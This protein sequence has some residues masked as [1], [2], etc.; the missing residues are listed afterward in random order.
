MTYSDNSHSR[1]CAGLGARIH[2]MARRY[3]SAVLP[4]HY[5]GQ[6]DEG[7]ATDEE[8]VRGMDDLEACLQQGRSI[9]AGGP[10]DVCRATWRGRDVVIK[11][12][13]HVGWM[14]SLRHSFKGS[15]ACRAWAN[16]RRLLRLGISTP[17]PLAFLDEHRGPFLWQSCLITEYVDAP[18]LSC[19]LRD[20]CVSEGRKR[21]LVHQTLRLIDRLG[22]YGIS[23]G[24]MKHTNILCPGSRIV[25]ADLDGMKV[26]R[27][28]WLS[29]SHRRRDIARFLRRMPAYTGEAPAAPQEPEPAFMR[30]EH[31]TGVLWVHRDYRNEYLEK[32]LS[33][34]QEALAEQ[35]RLEPVHS[36]GGS[37]VNRFLAAFQG[38]ERCVYC[39]E[40]VERSV[41]DRLKHLVRPSRAVRDM[42]ASSMLRRYG[43]QTAQ[44]VL[45]GDVRTGLLK[46]T[47][48]LVTLEITDA[49]SIFCCLVQEPETTGPCSWKERRRLLRQ[50]GLTV[51]RMHHE[52]IAHGD[53]RP[54]NTLVRRTNGRWEFCFID[55]ERTRK[56]LRL[57]S[58]LRLKN[59]VQVNM[60][61]Q[62]I[63]HTDRVRFF[64]AYLLMNPS[65][66]PRYKHWARRIM[67]VTRQR[68]LSLQE[69]G[70]L[71]ETPCGHATT[72]DPA[73]RRDNEA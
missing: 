14:H 10:I 44:V 64:Q 45:A 67:A 52:H 25:L 12:Y 26:H 73:P 24:D 71:G 61:S 8:I 41:L 40:F 2:S 27:L 59:L 16:G 37:H 62:G 17:Q 34:G 20:E 48:F 35:F 21:R 63:S 58:H 19:V 30:F 57:P 47:S 4:I 46:N 54:G 65:V 60:L 11:W 38:T 70:R 13:K 3:L 33:V 72:A 66:R 29:R 50:F 15:R 53:L 32:A 36:I 6:A 1:G 22:S 18:V 9:K 23:H 68:W 49:K 69:R 7:F 51:G 5:T 42:N 28:P 55:N 56:W 43:F 31:R 39:K